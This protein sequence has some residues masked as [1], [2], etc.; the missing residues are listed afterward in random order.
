MFLNIKQQNSIDK[1]IAKITI[2]SVILIFCLTLITPALST[3][4]E[5]T[6]KKVTNN[7]TN[8]S[9]TEIEIYWD[10]DGTQKASSILWGTLKPG[11][12]KTITLFIRNNDKNQI[13]L[14][15]Y[16]S[17][18]NPPD[19]ANYLKLNWDYT[20]QGIQFKE[21]VQVIFTLSVSENIKTAGTFSFDITIIGTE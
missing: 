6:G 19:I 12:N 1:K 13:T 9:R 16:T 10:K 15:F 4:P 21:T 8:N 3:K 7:G 18:W 5:I 2:I 20:G 11:T 14:N 17:N